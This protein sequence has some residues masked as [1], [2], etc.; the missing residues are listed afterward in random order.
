MLAAGALVVGIAWIA[1]TLEPR[2]QLAAESVP[3]ALAWSGASLATLVTS[4]GSLFLPARRAT[5][6][7][8]A[9]V[10]AV[11]MVVGAVTANTL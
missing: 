3:Y 2:G 1:S 4:V 10:I 7:A 6:L 5:L 11:A 9:G 8:T